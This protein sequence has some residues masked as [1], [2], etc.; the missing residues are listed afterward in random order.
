MPGQ[1]SSAVTGSTSVVGAVC[2]EAVPGRLHVICVAGFAS[3]LRP[4]GRKATLCCSVCRHSCIVVACSLKKP[5]SNF[6]ITVPASAGISTNCPE[7][8]ISLEKL[9]DCLLCLLVADIKLCWLM[10]GFVS[11]SG[12]VTIGAVFIELAV[13]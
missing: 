5:K 2:S 7:N 13:V 3:A 10:V 9:S 6:L 12:K 1:F 4:P 11:V 8:M